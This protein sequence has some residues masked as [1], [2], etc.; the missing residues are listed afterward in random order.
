MYTTCLIKVGCVCIIYV[1]G[2]LNQHDGLNEIT[3]SHIDTIYLVY[4]LTYKS[5]CILLLFC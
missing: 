4:K 5:F 3:I 2:V 1:V